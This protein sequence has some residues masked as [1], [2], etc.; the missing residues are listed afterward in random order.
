MK[1]ISSKNAD[2]GGCIRRS[3]EGKRVYKKRNY[4]F[5]FHFCSRI[6]KSFVEILNLGVCLLL[7]AHGCLG[8]LPTESPNSTGDSYSGLKVAFQWKYIEWDKRSLEITGKNFTLGNVFSQDVDIDRRGRIFVTTPRWLEGN[9][10][11]LSLLTNLEG[12][13]GPLLTPYP[14]ASWHKAD[15]ESI[16]HVFR[17]AVSFDIQRKLTKIS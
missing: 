17:V 16:V 2:S 7:F 5:F 10:I 11:T 9:P 4:F 8:Q 3:I 15:C 12:N 14:D 13:G 1:K 6:M